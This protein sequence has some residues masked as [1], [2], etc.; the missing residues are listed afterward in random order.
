MNQLTLSLDD[1]EGPL[2]LRLARAL[3]QAIRTGCV[4]PGEPLPTSRLLAEQL[5]INRH[6]VMRAYAELCAQGWIESQQ[7]SGYRVMHALP[8]EQSTAPKH[9]PQQSA[10]FKWQLARTLP[11]E[12]SFIKTYPHLT[13]N[14]AGGRPDLALFPFDEYRSCLNDALRRPD[15]SQLNYGNNRGEASLLEQAQRYLRRSR[16]LVDRDIM[17]VN[18]SQEAIYILAQLL[19]GPGDYVAVEALGYPPAWQALRASGAQLE[20]IAQDEY[21]ICPH[22]LEVAAQH[23][24]LKCL[25]LTP[26]HQYP[27]TVTLSRQRRRAIYQLAQQYQF[28]IIEDDYDH[29]FHYKCQPLAPMAA[30]DPA[31]LVIYLSSFSKVMYPAARCGLLAAPKVLVDALV[32]LRACINHKPPQLLQE[33]LARWMRGGGLERHIRRCTKKYQQRRENA[34][35]QVVAAQQRGLKL[36]CRPPDGGMALWIN[37]AVDT[38]ILADMA[39]KK[40]VF[41]Q[42]GAE[43]S[44][45]R[46]TSA[47]Q[48]IRLGFAG[49][50]R[51]AFNAGFGLL[52]ECLAL[53]QCDTKN[54]DD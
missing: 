3:Q 9:R 17:I 8:I 51:E 14:F 30:D 15:P 53:L 7:R 45:R 43:F 41:V 37:C 47:T 10:Q 38:T 52:M 54:T 50:E 19:L 48:Y 46:D 18:G 28:F 32:Q 4:A 11:S 12:N 21:G 42:H 2:Y 13:Y 33:A 31:Q 35:K 1:Y 34:L 26:L 22:A 16:A 25:Y 6:T 29:E 36:H 44:L 24:Q 40:G 27:S 49:L 39:F 20:P 5:G 23:C